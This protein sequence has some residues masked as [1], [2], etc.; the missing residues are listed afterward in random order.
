[1]FVETK[2][3][4]AEA[5]HQTIKIGAC[6]YYRSHRLPH[7]IPN[8]PPEWI[9]REGDRD[10]DCQV[11]AELS[12]LVAA[13]TVLRNADHWAGSL[14]RHIALSQALSAELEAFAEWHG[15]MAA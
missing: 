9:E 5:L 6:F 13:S 7:L 1:M 10:I 3:T 15:E 12:R 2:L 4:E 8:C 11:I 14:N